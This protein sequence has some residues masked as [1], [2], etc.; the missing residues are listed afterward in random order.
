LSCGQVNF[1]WE[2]L[3]AAI[4]DLPVISSGIALWS[5]LSNAVRL[6][7]IN[8]LGVM[9]DFAA[10][11][12]SHFKYHLLFSKIQAGLYSKVYARRNFTYLSRD[13]N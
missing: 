5:K 6:V 13:R 11:S 10:A 9:I 3:S 1:L 4:I 12:R 8:P 2:R 7:T